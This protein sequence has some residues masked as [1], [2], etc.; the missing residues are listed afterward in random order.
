MAATGPNYIDF[1]SGLIYGDLGVGELGTPAPAGALNHIHWT[2][3]HVPSSVTTTV[4]GDEFLDHHLDYM[5][6]RY[7]ACAREVL[8]AARAAVG[9]LKLNG[10]GAIRNDSGRRRVAGDHQRARRRR[11]GVLQHPLSGLR[12]RGPRRRDQI[13]G[14][15]QNHFADE[16]S[17]R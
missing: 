13:P 17:F 7:E 2:R 10:R 3:D 8:S 12:H 15:S 1:V 5:L 11:P 4:T 16:R 14:M 9:R 6:A